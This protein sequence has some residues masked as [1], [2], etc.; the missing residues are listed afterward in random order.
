MQAEINNSDFS[1]GLVTVYPSHVIPDGA[2]PS[3]NNVD[4]STSVGAIVKR[5]GQSVLYTEKTVAALPYVSGMY[6]FI[7]SAASKFIVV[8]ANDDVYDVTGAGTYTSIFSSAGLNGADVNFATLKDLMVFVSA[9]ITTQSWTGA[10][11]SANLGGTPPSNAK[12]ITAFKNRLWIANSSAGNSRLHYSAEGNPED[13]TTTG[14]T[15]AGFI[16]INDDDGDVITGIAGVGNVLMV[17][18]NRSIWKVVGVN[19]PYSVLPVSS[20]IGCVGP[21]SILAIDNFC[22]FLS[23]SGVYSV[24]E[25]RLAMMS[26]NIKP[27]IEALTSTV[28]IAAVAGRSRSNYWLSY[29]S[30]ADGLNDSAYILEYI[31]GIWFKYSNI[32]GSR[33]VTRDDGSL[34]LGGSDKVIVRLQEDT[35]ND[36][37]TAITMTW[38]SKDYVLGSFAKDKQLHDLFLSAEVLSG[39]TY[40]AEHLIEGKLQ[41]DSISFAL[42]AINTSDTIVVNS[43]YMPDTSQGKY[44]SLRFTNAQSA[45]R[46]K[47]Y[48]Y[49][50]GVEVRN[51][52]Q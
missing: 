28:K 26:Y 10:G 5:L 25:D 21:K 4:L 43:T 22:L 31:S 42:D 45:K 36:E 24:S 44:F 52:V 8:A 35:S 41:T 11:A 27:T 51:R 9:N 38:D 7:T 16:D 47:L 1:Q 20:I 13:W 48:E 32:K 49:S 37:S 17:F 30:D 2:S 19:P 23:N 39:G 6:Q 34:I 12:Y 14:I 40:T 46:P 3:M 18:K 33:F 29:D 15:G 50:V